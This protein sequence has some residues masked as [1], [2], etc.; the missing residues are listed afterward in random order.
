MR[1]IIIIIDISDV[2][3][4][5]NRFNGM[6]LFCIIG[7]LIQKSV[8]LRVLSIVFII[9]WFLYSSST[10]GFTNDYLVINRLITCNRF[11]IIQKLYKLRL[12]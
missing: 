8:I 9:N 11:S 3:N 12:R 10:I 6:L 7:D 1:F 5:L 4:L 2:I